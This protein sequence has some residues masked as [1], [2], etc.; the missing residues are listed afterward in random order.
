MAS[1]AEPIINKPEDRHAPVINEAADRAL[2]RIII[3]CGLATLVLLLL[4]T[5]V[6]S[7]VNALVPGPLHRFLD[8]LGLL[9]VML[10][11][12]IGMNKLFGMRLKLGREFVANKHWREAVA[13]LDPFAGTG[14][15]FLDKTG[16][17]HFLLSIAYQHTGDT[18][19]AAQSRA[20]VQRH[21]P[22]EWAERLAEPAARTQENRPAPPKRRPRRR[23]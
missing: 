17:A 13:A 6:M 21:R 2:G 11:F 14:Q 18:R 3:R 5:V 16:E 10:P 20:F 7:V 12:F 9:V 1:P 4:M 19:K 22:G 8:T 23:H 15:R